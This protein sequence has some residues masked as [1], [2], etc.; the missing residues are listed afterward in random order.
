MSGQASRE[1]VV[2]YGSQTGTAQEVAERVGREGARLHFLPRVSCLDSFPLASLPATRLAVYVV[3]TTGQGDPPDNMTAAWRFLRRRSLPPSS[4]TGHQFGVIGLGD[5]SYPKFNHVAKKLCRRLVQL[6]GTALLPL[7]L[8]D[9]QHDLG[10]DFVVDSWLERW[11]GLALQVFPLPP[12]LTPVSKEATP[13]PRYRMLPVPPGP[14]VETEEGGGE[15]DWVDGTVVSCARLTPPTH[16][17]D[18]R[19]VVLDTPGLQ[20]NPGDVA[21]VWNIIF[22]ALN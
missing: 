7:G 4:L 21:Q 13:P 14:G 12:G 16:H 8:G 10:P 1:L 11:W 19:L 2:L 6:G 20:Y 22:T 9:D 17:Q 5:S 18:T 3:S 15:E